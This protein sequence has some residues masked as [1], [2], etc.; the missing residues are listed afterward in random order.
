MGDTTV[1]QG[2]GAYTYVWLNGDTTSSVILTPSG[3]LPVSVTGTDTNG[4]V[5]TANT[6]VNVHALPNVSVSVAV[7]STCVY[8]SAT[9][10]N[11]TPAGGVYSGAGVSGSSFNPATAGV[12]SHDIVY[13]YSDAFGCG[14]SDTISLS[15]IACLGVEEES[16]E[17]VS[18]YPNPT[19]GW[20]QVSGTWTSDVTV[21]LADIS[22]RIVYN[23]TMAAAPLFSLSLEG[24]TPGMYELRITSGQKTTVK[25]VIVA[26]K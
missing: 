10:L 22:G 7:D 4:C 16:T 13:A 21:E 3:N 23:K 12:G 25:R 24:Y 2:N 15:V 9:T 6:L 17:G 26:A 1:L 5:A 19:T 18:V 20:I 11:G 14:A 8:Y